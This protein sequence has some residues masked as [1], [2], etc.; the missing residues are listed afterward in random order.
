MSVTFISQDAIILSREKIN[1]GFIFESN[2]LFIE[3]LYPIFQIL[4]GNL[5]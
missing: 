2:I 4:P 1:T 3:Y 5:F